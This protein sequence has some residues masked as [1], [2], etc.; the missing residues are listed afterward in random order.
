VAC[1]GCHTDAVT[2]VRQWMSGGSSA[3]S[4][5]AHYTGYVWARHGLGDAD[6]ATGAGRVLFTAGQGVLAPLELLGGPTLEHF[7]V[8]RHRIIDHLIDE[9]VAAG[10]VGQVVELAAGLSPRGL[11][12]TRRHPDLTYVEVDLPEMAAR[13]DGILAAKGADPRRH[14]AVAADVLDDRAFAAVF[15]GPGSL[16]DPG[17]GTVVVTEGLLN[18]FPRPAVLGLWRRTARELARFPVGRYYSDLHLA[19]RTGRLDRFFA[20]GLGA[21]VR[22]GVH[23]HFADS[24]DAL[25]SLRASGFDEAVLHAP[26]DFAAT[27]PDMDGAGADRVRVIEATVGRDAGA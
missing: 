3:I 17:R 9:Q 23:L 16:L 27:L 10:H 6:L 26:R 4:P 21:F 5:T 12:L 1:S 8:A 7:L 22:G 15:S 2:W 18:Y 19:S 25:G 20:A 13:K 11:E 14:R 24:P